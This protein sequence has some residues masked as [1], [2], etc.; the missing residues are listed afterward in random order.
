MVQPRHGDGLDPCVSGP[1]AA[2]GGRGP[3]GLQGQAGLQR[4]FRQP[5]QLY[6]WGL[7][8][9]DWHQHLRSHRQVR[10]VPHAGPDRRRVVVG[11]LQGPHPH[12][13]LPSTRDDH[14]SG[15]SIRGPCPRG[16]LGFPH[17]QAAGPRP[18]E[19]AAQ[20]RLQGAAELERRRRGVLLPLRREPQPEAHRRAPGPHLRRLG[21]AGR[22]HP[23]EVLPRTHLGR[24][25]P[26]QGRKHPR[27][28]GA[29]SGELASQGP[30]L[31][32]CRTPNL[33]DR[34]GGRPSPGCRRGQDPP[35]EGAASGPSGA[36]RSGTRRICRRGE[37][38]PES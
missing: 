16:P 31:R 27:G 18:P 29:D 8:R 26:T 17:G 15:L 28:R 33:G 6:L 30:R 36:E 20:G 14:R 11:R 21:Q 3:Q 23:D 7:P 24:A 2:L 38:R 25:H 19:R 32:G 13:A 9:R 34:L 35:C 4:E 10:R 37:S 5:R 22:G 1:V 12:G